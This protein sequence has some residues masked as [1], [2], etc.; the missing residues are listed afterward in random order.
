ML[1]GQDYNNQPVFLNE[2]DLDRQGYMIGLPG[3]GKTTM[4]LAIASASSMKRL[5]GMIV[6]DPH[7]DMSYDLLHLI[8]PSAADRVNCSIP[9]SRWSAPS[10]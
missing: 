6:F 3:T 9:R 10:A 4:M 8:P 2:H 7:G 1:V 5:G